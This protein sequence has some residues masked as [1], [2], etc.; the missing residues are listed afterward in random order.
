[1]ADLDP[2]RECNP[3][4]AVGRLSGGRE[5]WWDALSGCHALYLPR[6]QP[7]FQKNAMV[8]NPH[9]GP[10]LLLFVAVY[11]RK[12][13]C[14]INTCT[15]CVVS[16]RLVKTSPVIISF[17]SPPQP[18]SALI[19][20]RGRGIRYFACSPPGPRRLDAPGV[21]RYPMFYLLDGR[22]SS[23]DFT[24][25]PPQHLLCLDPSERPPLGFLFFTFP[26]VLNAPGTT[27]YPARHFWLSLVF[28]PR[29]L[30][31]AE[32][33]DFPPPAA[34]HPGAC[35]P[36]LTLRASRAPCSHPWPL[37]GHPFL[38][39]ALPAPTTFTPAPAW[40]DFTPSH[41]AEVPGCTIPGFH[42]CGRHSILPPPRASSARQI[43]PAHFTRPL[44]RAPRARRY[45]PWPP[46]GHPIL[47]CAPRAPRCTL[48]HATEVPGCTIPGF[49]RRGRHSILPPPRALSAPAT[50]TLR[51]SR[52]PRFYPWPPPGH[53]ILPRALAP[54][55]LPPPRAATGAAGI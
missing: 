22:A 39:R 21:F 27:I 23:P 44:P 25:L 11:P 55:L 8:D 46:P 40:P 28:L 32:L 50:L 17:A 5:R 24:S 37:P 16:H 35:L 34:P 19:P 29:S 20:R 4:C 3:L 9:G 2:P 42:W 33:P 47:L 10:H 51:A 49:H 43:D 15:C 1:M 36:P 54:V 7:C 26:R 38:L 12:K 13:K 18:P 48:S 14:R 6:F 45:Y 41:A 53:L 52:A 30:I 31:V